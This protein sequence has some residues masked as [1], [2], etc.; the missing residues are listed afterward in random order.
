[1]K[2]IFLTIFIVTI[3]IM[4]SCESHTYDEISK[5]TTTEITYTDN[6]SKIVSSNCLECHSTNTDKQYPEL[7]TYDQ[8][9]EEVA[10]GDFLCRISGTS[11]GSIMPQ[12]GKMSQ[13]L[14]DVVYTWKANG[15]KK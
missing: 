1:M 6:V 9:K 13:S 8:V 7:D 5:T 2:K 12:S 4:A 3:I 14:I 10:N 15:Y 11:C